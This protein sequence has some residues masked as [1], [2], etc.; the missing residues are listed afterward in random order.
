MALPTKHI[1][2]QGPVLA[3]LGQTA[4]SAVMQRFG[5]GGSAAAFKVP[6]DPVEL[7][8]TPRAPD[9]VRDYV[10]HVGGDPS[11]YKRTIP[12]HFFP[13]WGFPLAA[14]T[15]RGV[16][17]PM[18][19]VLNGGCRLEING[20]L[21]AGETL[22]VTARLE[23]V[24]DNGSRAVLHQRVATGTA[25]EPELVVGHL[26][27]IVPLGGGDKKDKPRK[28]RQRVP[29]DAREVG[30]WRLPA[31]AGLAFAML[32]GDFNPVHWVRPYA[33]AFGFKN[34]ILHGFSTMAR[35]HEGLNRGLFAG[36][37]N[38]IRVLDVKFT[39]PLTLPA[40]VGLYVEGNNV[41]VGAAPGSRAY[42]VGTFE[43]EQS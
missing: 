23:D 8:L 27:A 17:Y 10:R 22:N 21:P 9:L 42:L 19:K 36:D 33:K 35:A 18:Q 30:R 3:S 39:A 16:P 28:E 34:T 14:K 2:H 1:I 7:A 11:A 4:L 29:P 6:S 25:A 32:T 38:R 5:R 26:Y 41:Y 13:Q 12:A 24:D 40:K 15:L 43:T 37:V 20:P 31:D